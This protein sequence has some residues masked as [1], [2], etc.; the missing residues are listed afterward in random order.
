M[1]YIRSSDLIHLVAEGVCPY[2][3]LFLFFLIPKPWQLLFYSLFLLACILLIC[4]GI[5]RIKRLGCLNYRP[6]KAYFSP[7][8]TQSCQFRDFSINNKVK[9]PNM[10]NVASDILKSFPKIDIFLLVVAASCYNLSF[11]LKGI[12]QQA[13][14]E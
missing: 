2:P 14:E 13:T 4:Y 3:N 8:L 10:S 1:L 11:L 9:Q 6:G 5:L 7:D 12:S